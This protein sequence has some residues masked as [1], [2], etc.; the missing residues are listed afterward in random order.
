M[1]RTNP[2]KFW[3][4]INP[5]RSK[6]LTL[7]DDDNNPIPEEESSHVLNNFFCSVFTKEPDG[8]LPE[9]ADLDHPVM[10]DI[11]FDAHG[12]MKLIESLKLTSSSGIDGINSKVLK[13]TKNIVSIILCHLFQQSLSTGVLPQDWKVGKIIPVPKK[14]SS[15]SCKN[16]R[17][18]SLTSVCSKLME[19]VVYSHIVKFLVSVKFFYPNQH[20]FLKG[21]SC[22]SQLALFVN[23][24][25]S[26]L[27]VNI[28]TDTLFLDFEKAFDKVPHKR[29]LL[30]LSHLNLNPLVMNWLR[31]F[32]THRE[33][34]VY[35]NKFSSPR[36]PVTSGVPQGTVLGPLLFLIYINDLPSNISST[37][38][39]F[40][41][42]CVIYRPISSSTDVDILQQDLNRIVTWCKQW[43]MSINITK[44]CLISFHRRHSHTPHKYVLF[45]SEVSSVPSC[46][47]LGIT[48]TQNLTWSSH[49]MNISNEANRTLGFIRRNL[50][51]STPSIKTLA[52]LTFVRPKLEYA[53]AIW[54]PHQSNLSLT[55]EK[56]QNRAT[57][58]IY[59]DYSYYTSVSALKSRANLPNLETRRKITRLCLFHMFYHS[60]L[61]A[62]A[63]SP[64]HRISNRIS[65]E[66]AVYTPPTRTTAHSR[67]F[68]VTTSRDW[69]DLPLD[70]VH[71]INAIH[72]KNA[73]TTIFV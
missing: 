47:Y 10:S 33:Q 21:L 31:N 58:F 42:D 71:H 49:I 22:D 9:F 60:P 54:D 1:L 62:S 2:R 32:L 25:S 44:T 50:R 52:Y 68:F 17:P 27:D 66:K 73:I 3:K 55:L 16:Y 41:D 23:D 61:G 7:H 18:I 14:G 40:A 69:N 43:L 28:P 35:A 48:L 11:L 4:T 37:I 30:K 15:L 65:H 70:A 29:L 46:K 72:F 24:I 12:I 63:I 64:A 13:N 53:S 51:F 6:P 36:S 19:H 56:I 45:G 59:S 39:L 57:R 8:E 26:S 34:F 38:R 5:T 20:G 67:S